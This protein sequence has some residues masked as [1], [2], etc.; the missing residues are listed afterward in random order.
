MGLSVR[1]WGNMRLPWVVLP[2]LSVWTSRRGIK[3]PPRLFPLSSHLTIVSLGLSS[4]FGESFV[5]GCAPCQ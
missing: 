2:S 1:A 4:D 5:K 3:R